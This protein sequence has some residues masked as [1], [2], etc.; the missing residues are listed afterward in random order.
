MGQK[1][2]YNDVQNSHKPKGYN[3]PPRMPWYPAE[4]DHPSSIGYSG[5]SNMGYRDREHAVQTYIIQHPDYTGG[6]PHTCSGD[7]YGR[8][9]GSFRQPARQRQPAQQFIKKP[10][11]AVSPPA[12]VLDR[13]YPMVTASQ[14]R[15]PLD[16]FNYAGK[17]LWTGLQG[18]NFVIPHPCPA[19]GVYRHI[20]NGK[21]GN[22]HEKD[23]YCRVTEVETRG[24]K[25]RFFECIHCHQ[26][27][28]GF[29]KA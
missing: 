17:C 10:P 20:V 29:E 14:S 23:F 19:G 21:E 8:N 7:K 1:M 4:Y 2:S 13:T 28:N 5:Y 26:E 6:V 16:Q 22:F 3:R 18:P 15:R 25:R 27:W 11:I 9:R 12:E 24:P